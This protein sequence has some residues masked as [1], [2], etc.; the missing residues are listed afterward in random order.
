MRIMV[1]V[2]ALAVCL[3]SPASTASEQFISEK[4]SPLKL[5]RHVNGEDATT[6]FTG[7]VRLSGRFLIAWEV[8][9]KAPRYL[10]VLFLPD[11]DSARVLPHPAGSATV[12]QLLLINDEPATELLLGPQA[13]AKVLA[14]EVLSAEGKST[15]VIGD[16]RS[17]IDCD[18]RWYLA[19]LLS[20][21]SLGE[22]AV[23]AGETL[24]ISC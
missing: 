19:R 23:G 10:R 4:P 6:Q 22:V 20:V 15:V 9:N 13:A 7:K 8:F 21:S 1:G 2:F 5:M 18:H 17:V 24:H 3:A 12:E 16:Y 11:N 14:K